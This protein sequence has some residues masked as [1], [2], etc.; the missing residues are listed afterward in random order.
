MWIWY[1]PPLIRKWKKTVYLDIKFF[2]RPNHVYCKLRK[3]FH[4]EKEFDMAPKPLIGKEVYKRQQD[5]DVVFWKKQKGPVEK[6]IWKKRLAFF[7]IPYWSSLDVRDCLD[8][9]HVEKIYAIVWL[10]HF[11]TSKARQKVLRNRVKI[12]WWWVYDKS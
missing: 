3:D 11:S 9:M 6:N 4:R 7:D 5:I 2:L 12:W 10:K 8:V 1:M